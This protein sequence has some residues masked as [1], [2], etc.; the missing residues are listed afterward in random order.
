[1][2]SNVPK[3]GFVASKTTILFEPLFAD[4]ASIVP[5]IPK[6]LAIV[7][8]SPEV[9]GSPTTILEPAPET[10]HG[11]SVVAFFNIL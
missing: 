4:V 6:P 11:A 8:V 10:V 5:V 9:V 3:V 7:K 2:A 1:M